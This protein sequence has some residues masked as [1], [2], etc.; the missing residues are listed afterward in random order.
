MVLK[1][2]IFKDQIYSSFML[3]LPF[4]RLRNWTLFS[5]YQTFF[6][7][8]RKHYVEYLVKIVNEHKL[9]PVEIMNLEDVTTLL[10]RENIDFD[11]Q[12]ENVDN[13]TYLRSLQNKIKELRPLKWQLNSFWM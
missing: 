9:D 6:I 1:I 10:K 3:S 4:K 13:E 2:Y 7:I 5:Q 8:Y 11:D 12:G